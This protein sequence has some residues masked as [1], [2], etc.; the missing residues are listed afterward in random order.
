MRNFTEE[1]KIHSETLGFDLASIEQGTPE[2]HKS[3]A[4]V[5]TASKAHYLLMGRKT[6]G[7]A[8]YMDELIA[9]V[10]TGRVPD[11]INAKALQ[12]GKDNEQDAREAYSAATFEV[13]T[14]YGFIY[15]DN[16]M[17]AG[18]SPDGMIN[19]KPKGLELKVPWSSAVWAGFAGRGQIKK[20]E[21]AQVQ[22]SLMVTGYESW[23]FAKFNP[24]NTNCKKLHYI[25]IERDE[26]M[27]AN[28][29][30]GLEEFVEDMDKALDN[31]GLQ[32]GQQWG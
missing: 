22:F 18:C 3:R 15:R 12:W 23:G 20:E 30:R 24:R 27:I 5:V 6:Q 19:G 13:V 7:R 31:L 9:A 1:S 28:L 2:W 26:E 17:R 10:A 29:E 8:T 16:S 14:D 32:F 25:E 21:V 11:E 4:G